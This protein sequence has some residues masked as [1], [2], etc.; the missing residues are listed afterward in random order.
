MICERLNKLLKR[1]KN[2]ELKLATLA[3]E[4]NAKLK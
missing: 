3:E 2:I 4:I 1:K